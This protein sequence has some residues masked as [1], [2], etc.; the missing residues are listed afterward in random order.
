MTDSGVCQLCDRD[1]FHED[2]LEHGVC[3]SCCLDLEEEASDNF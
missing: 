3:L 1:G 2:Q